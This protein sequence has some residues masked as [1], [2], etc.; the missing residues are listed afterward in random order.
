MTIGHLALGLVA[1]RLQPGSRKG[2]AQRLALYAL[3]AVAPDLDLVPI[4]L[5]WGH[6][7]PLGHRGATHSLAVAALVAAA[8]AF[9]WPGTSR[10]RTGLFAFLAM[11]SHGLVDPLV[12]GSSGTALLWPFANVLF[13]WGGFQ[14][15]PAT[16]V[17]FELL[18]ANGFLHLAFEV[19]LFAPLAVYA[20][21]PRT[22][23]GAA[24]VREI[25]AWLRRAGR[26]AP[27]PA[28]TGEAGREVGA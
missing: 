19:V 21:W 12:E 5:G 3:L 20:L 6:L 14:P 17:G 26:G 23:R 27:V 25:A 18:A 10:V 28:L 15:V 16:P 24:R 8:V 11:A 1:A 2:L 4:A 22:L 13:T 7:V 9:A